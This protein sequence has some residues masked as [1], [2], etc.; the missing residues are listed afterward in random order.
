MQR[1]RHQMDVEMVP[2]KAQLGQRMQGNSV[3]V[4]YVE[5]DGQVARN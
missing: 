5:V 1:T 2:P 3:A 4:V